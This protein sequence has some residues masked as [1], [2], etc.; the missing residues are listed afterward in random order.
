MIRIGI[1]GGIGSGK[2]TVSSVWERMGARVVYA[3]ALAKS[4][5]VRDKELRS[6]IV[7][8]FGEDAYKPDGTLDRKKL[9]KM[10]F[11]E[12]KV[13]E[14]NRLVHPVVYRELEKLEQEAEKEGVAMF[15]REAAL[16]LDNGRPENLDAV[17]LVT[18]PEEQRIERVMQRDQADEKHVRDRINKQKDFSELSSLAD[19]VITNDESK[20]KLEKKAEIIYKE[21]IALEAG[22]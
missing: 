7:E 8:A 19:L 1:T 16:L 10:A 20:E 13:S 14:L 3:D 21:L 15:V 22:K 9:S 2:T 18:A 12:G 5:M 11:E 17:I 6:Q 4:L